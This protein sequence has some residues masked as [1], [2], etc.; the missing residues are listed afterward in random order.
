MRAATESRMLGS[1]GGATTLAIGSCAQHNTRKVQGTVRY[2][3]A[4]TSAILASLNEF[5][6]GVADY[7]KKKEDAV[8]LIALVI[9]F[10]RGNMKR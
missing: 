7:T 3:G 10:D 5:S 2:I 4:D 6:R 8:D 1:R 9:A